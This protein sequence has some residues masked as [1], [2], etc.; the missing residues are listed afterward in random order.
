METGR[1]EIDNSDVFAIVSTY[2]TKSQE[3]SLWEAHRQYIDIQAM[4]EGSE[5]IGHA[6]IDTL[7]ITQPY[8]PAKDIT[9]LRGSGDMFILKPGM[10]AIF[11]PTD[12]HMPGVCA[13]GN[14]QVKK[15]VIKVRAA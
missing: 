3:E 2:K 5:R 9:A 15:I 13:D 12:A 14:Q 6:P 1:H 8:D 4:I 10:F 11:Y 7:N